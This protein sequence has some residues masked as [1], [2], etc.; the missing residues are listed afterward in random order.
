VRA[1]RSQ[2]GRSKLVG[3]VATGLLLFFLAPIQR[4]AE[5]LSNSALPNV[6][7]SPEY[8]D[9]RKMQIYGEALLETLRRN[10]QVSPADRASLNRLRAKLDRSGEEATHLEQE[11]LGAV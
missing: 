3:L 2:A 11:I 8:L 10:K 7:D 4:W 9:L 1:T 5:R 6:E